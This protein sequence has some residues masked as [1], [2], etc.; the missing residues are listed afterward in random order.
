MANLVEQVAPWAPD[1]ARMR[2]LVSRT[3]LLSQRHPVMFPLAVW[4]NRTKRRAQ[5][6]LSDASWTTRRVSEN[7]EVQ[8]LE[9]R[10]PLLRRLGESEMYLQHNK[11]TNLALASAKM[12]GLLICPGETFSF[13]KVVGS[14]TRR[15]G[16]LDG[17]RLSH[18]ETVAGVGGGICQLSNVVHW[19]VLHSSLTVT[20][21]SEHSFDPFP[22]SDRVVPWGTGCTIV[23]NYVDLQ[24]RNDTDSTFQ[25]RVSVSDRFLEGD[26]RADR[27]QP[28]TYHVYAANE[29]FYRLGSDL[30]RANQIWRTVTDSRTGERLGEELVR[31][32]CALV[33]Y[34]PKGAPIQDLAG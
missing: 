32:N 11:V 25:L 23:Y 29:R 18:G 13:N 5:W 28:L 16:Y 10:S 30:F 27:A 4:V 14:C 34:L 1:P 2:G 26:L 33:K 22:D 15:G 7:L 9:H 3:P 20:E 19:L 21:R 31:S 12:D 24:V 8:I 17:M 6:L